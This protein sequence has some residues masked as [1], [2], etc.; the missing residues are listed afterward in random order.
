MA[1]LLA[2]SAAFL[3]MGGGKPVSA[4]DNLI[5]S[6]DAA[7]EGLTPQ[8]PGARIK[9]TIFTNLGSFLQIGF[10]VSHLDYDGTW[11]Y[12][13]TQRASASKDAAEV[14]A[15]LKKIHIQVGQ[16]YL[17]EMAGKSL[18][19]QLEKDTWYTAWDL[20]GISDTNPSA[21]TYLRRE[22]HFANN[23]A[24]GKPG[25]ADITLISNSGYF[26]ANGGTGE[27][28]FKHIT[29][30]K[31]DAELYFVSGDPYDKIN[32][33][34]LSYP[35]TFAPVTPIDANGQTGIIRLADGITVNSFNESQYASLGAAAPD[36]D[37][38]GTT[39]TANYGGQ[40]ET[41]NLSASHITN[42]DAAAE[43]TGTVTIT[44]A[45][46]TV[47][48]NINV[49]GLYSAIAVTKNPDK[50]TY[51]L[52]KAG[53]EEL[54]LTGL[55][56]KGTLIAGG[57]Q[58]EIPVNPAMVSGLDYLIAGTQQITVAFAQFKAYFNVEVVDAHPDSFIRFSYGAPTIFTDQDTVIPL[59]FDF[60]GI[61][62]KDLTNGSPGKFGAIWNVENDSNVKTK[63]SM[64][65]SGIQGLDDGW[66]TIGE[67]MEKRD[68]YGQKLIAFVSQYATTLMFHSDS[69]YFATAE[70][71]QNCFSLDKIEAIKAEAGFFWVTLRGY[72]AGPNPGYGDSWG[73][74]PSDGYEMVENAILR[75]TF[76][77]EPNNLGI[78]WLRIL[79]QNEDGAVASDA[80]TIKTPAAKLVYKPGE[81]LDV[82]G[83]VITVK[84][85][86]GFTEDIEALNDWAGFADLSALGEQSVY[87]RY[88]EVRINFTVTVSET[89]DTGDEPGEESETTATP[90]PAA[91]GCNGCN[92]ANAGAAGLLFAGIILFAVKRKIF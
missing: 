22:M 39:V 43:G 73:G 35:V 68:I 41:I 76:V 65:I 90:K 92:G 25:Q 46:C 79:K 33:S 85:Q 51:E 5:M 59:E 44:Y 66:Y 2:L 50:L 18:T 72:G 62:L 57:G 30:I 45:G 75:D 60:A 87:V 4:A 67:L 13:D 20:G 77:V 89:D 10:D 88:N 52:G 42:V 26:N 40:T 29:K 49:A 91:T 36:I 27:F 37:I 6:A 16:S 54:D 31:L 84:Y 14:E 19:P 47:I 28:G 23:G 8:E 24:N 70:T 61:T 82:T 74:Y 71:M 63:V 64:K 12:H 38:T 86:D 83:M 1:A 15:Y 32:E 3:S 69:R 21:E 48:K 80:I 56:V 58:E 53:D 7:V 34:V 78:R 81:S 55:I 9:S 11:A 17:T